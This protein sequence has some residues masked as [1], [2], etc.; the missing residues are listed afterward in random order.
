MPAFDLLAEYEGHAAGAVI[1]SG[2]VVMDT[3]PE[4]REQQHDD[5]VGLVVLAQVGEERLDAFG[6]SFPQHRMAGALPSMGIEGAVVAVKDPAPDLAYVRLGDAL[7]LPSDR[8]VRILHRRR[9]RL[10][11]DLDDVLAL[12]RIDRGLA[13]IIHHGAAADRR[14]IHLGEA[15]ENVGAL[16]ALHL[17]QESVPLQ[18]SGDAGHRHAGGDQRARQARSHADDLHDI[19]FI[20]IEFARD[21]AEPAFGPNLLRLTRVPDVHGP[22]VGAR[23]VFE[24]DAVQHSEL[25]VIPEFLHRRHVVWDGVVLVEMDHLV[26]GDTNRRPVITVQ[27]VVVRDHCVQVVVAAGELQDHDT[28]VIS[29]H[30]VYLLDLTGLSGYAN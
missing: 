8:G 3:T 18:R 6:H 21:A 29:C 27:R 25:L 23:R 17:R 11:H 20:W 5:V 9:V 15:I 1:G 4:L 10:G 26:V 24:A 16:I 19:F 22:E 14:A 7:Q 30:N 13:E 28:R 12:E 2:A